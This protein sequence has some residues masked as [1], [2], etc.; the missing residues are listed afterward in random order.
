[1]NK[2]NDTHA[3]NI[4]E[5]LRNIAKQY[6]IEIVSAQRKS[7]APID[8]FVSFHHESYKTILGIDIHKSRLPGSSKYDSENIQSIYPEKNN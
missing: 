3:S 7:I 4:L 1:M 2:S 6:T 8:T 5:Q